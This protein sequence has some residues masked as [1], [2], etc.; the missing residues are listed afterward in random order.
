[1]NSYSQYN[2]DIHIAEE[3]ERRGI[4]SG[5]LLEIGAWDA[6][7][8]SNSRALIEAGWFAILVEPSPGPMRRLA[9]EYNR[10]D[11][12]SLVQACVMPYPGAGMQRLVLSDDGLSSTDPETVAKWLHEAGYFG[13]VWVPAIT[14]PDITLQFGGDFQFISIDAEGVSVPILFAML[15]NDNCPR[16]AVICCEHDGR[17]AEACGVAERAGYRPLTINATNLVLARRG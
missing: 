15:Q 11:L 6:K 17:I 10:R 12:V 2:E 3:L 4:T 9:E 5:R 16:P 14:I 13:S 8:F 1:M 7:K